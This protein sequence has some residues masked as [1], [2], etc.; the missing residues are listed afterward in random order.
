[1]NVLEI[2]NF[3]GNFYL[4]FLSV[5]YCIFYYDIG[6][7]LYLLNCFIYNILRVWIKKMLVFI[8]YFYNLI[9]EDLMFNDEKSFFGMNSDYN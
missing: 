4:K 8:D 1:M 9:F 7:C 2:L 5:F 6:W 3:Y